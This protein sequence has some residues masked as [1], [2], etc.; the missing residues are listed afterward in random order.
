MISLSMNSTFWPSKDQ[1]DF[2][3]LVHYTLAYGSYEECLQLLKDYDIDDIKSA[4]LTP[5]L[6]FYDRS[7]LGFAQLILKVEVD[8]SKYIKNVSAQSIR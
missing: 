4:F 5:K 6:G 7:S 2:Y 3:N 1:P 8:A